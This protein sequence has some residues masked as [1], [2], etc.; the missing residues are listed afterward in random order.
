MLLGANW[1]NESSNDLHELIFV[2]GD[3]WVKHV[4]IFGVYCW[5]RNL[6]F[7]QNHAKLD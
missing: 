7:S 4:E 6:G 5:E 2:Q 3:E 1:V